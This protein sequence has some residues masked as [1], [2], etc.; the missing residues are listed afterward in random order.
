MTSLWGTQSHVK[1]RPSPV[2]KRLFQS[3]DKNKLQR[4]QNKIKK[5]KQEEKHPEK[6]A[7]TNLMEDLHPR[8]LRP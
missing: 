2:P 7:E 1:L 8:D 4:G 6:V 5:K 3:Q